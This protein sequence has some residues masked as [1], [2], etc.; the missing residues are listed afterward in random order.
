MQDV[1][2]GD[3]GYVRF[4]TSVSDKMEVALQSCL[5]RRNIGYTAMESDPEEVRLTRLSIAYDSPSPLA[6]RTFRAKYG[7]DVTSS[8]LGLKS[9]LTRAYESQAA[10]AGMARGDARQTWAVCNA[11]MRRAVFSPAIEW[12]ITSM[13]RLDERIQRSEAVRTAKRRWSRCMHSA[14]HRLDA[15]EDAPQAVERKVFTVARTSGGTI[16]MRTARQLHRWELDLA[17]DDWSCR[18]SSYTAT[19]RRTRDQLERAFIA[20]HAARASRVRSDLS[21]ELSAAALWRSQRA[22]ATPSTGSS[23]RLRRMAESPGP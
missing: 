18:A 2:S 23:T 4:E 16:A 20:R 22:A 6:D 1:L 11:R 3:V 10:P 15:F 13:G 8:L 17:G 5:A 7:Y 19:F 21:L 9:P 12:W 14:G